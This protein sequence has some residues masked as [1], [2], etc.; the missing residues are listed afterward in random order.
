MAGVIESIGSGVSRFSVGDRVV[1]SASCGGYAQKIAVRA[2]Q[3][4]LIPEAMPFEEAAGLVLTYAT[5]YYALNDRAALKTGGRCS[6][7]VPP[8]ASAPPR[9]NSARPLRR[10]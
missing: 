9:S 3:C 2:E 4:W 7:S 8:A 6:C 1:A 5:S 10:A